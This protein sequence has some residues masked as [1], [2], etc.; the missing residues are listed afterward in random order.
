MT[1]PYLQ[2]PYPDS[3]DPLANGADDMRALA[4]AID[5]GN[6]GQTDTQY[7]QVVLTTN[8]A[9][10]FGFNY[11]RWYA[12]AMTTG[13]VTSF[14]GWFTLIYEQVTDQ[15]AG[16]IAYRRGGGEAINAGIR[17]FWMASGSRRQIGV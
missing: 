10:G 11:K 17:L 3:A 4:E 9:G 6:M 8:A 2:I 7:G 1:T 13:D 12:P 14:D 5:A 15:G 16:G